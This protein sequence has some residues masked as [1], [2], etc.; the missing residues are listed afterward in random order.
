MKA[1]Y[2]IWLLLL[3]TATGTFAQDVQFSQFYAVPTHLN[4]AFVGSAHKPRAILHQRV[5]WPGL[6]A[7]YITSFFSGDTWVQ[8]YRS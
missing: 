3:F 1:F 4:P 2:Y 6:Q 5:Q 8:K 7:R